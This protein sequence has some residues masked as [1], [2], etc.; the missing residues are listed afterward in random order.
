MMRRTMLYIGLLHDYGDPARGLSYE[1]WNFQRPLERW[2]AE[3]DWDFVAWCP[4][5]AERLAGTVSSGGAG[6][7]V[8]ELFRRMVR[9]TEPD[10]IF[11]VPFE[12]ELAPETLRAVRAEAALVGRDMRVVGWFSDDHW[13]FDG[14]TARY[15]PALLGH[16]GG[17]G[18]VGGGGVD[19][20]GACD[21]YVTTCAG[22]VEKYV[23]AG[24]MRDRVILSQWAVNELVC[25]PSAHA[26]IPMVDV[27]F[28]G[29]A[30]GNRGQLLT[31]MMGEL[32]RIGPEVLG[33]EVTAGIWGTGWRNGRI[34]YPQTVEVWG[35]SRVTL[36]L[37]NAARAVNAIG[38]GIVGGA[39]A[40][41][42]Q[43]KGRHFE[44]AACGGFQLTQPVGGLEECFRVVRSD[45]VGEETDAEIV[46]SAAQNGRDLAY[47][48]AGWLRPEYDELRRRIGQAARARVLA[49]HTWSRR[50]DDI[51]TRVMAEPVLSGAR[52]MTVATEGS[53]SD[54]ELKVEV[55]VGEAAP[56]VIP[57]MDD[58]QARLRGART[59]E[60][61]I[62][63]AARQEFGAA[64]FPATCIVL[65]NRNGAEV[66]PQCLDAVERNTDVP[67]RIVIGDNASDD[68]SFDIASQWAAQKHRRE[69]VK[70]VR[71]DQNL[72]CPEGRHRLLGLM[73]R[74]EKEE[75]LQRAEYVCFLDNDT[76]VPQGWLRLLIEAVEDSGGVWGAVGPRSNMI[77]GPQYISGIC[78]NEGGGVLAVG[79]DGRF[80]G[81]RLPG[82]KGAGAADD[83]ADVPVLDDWA[84]GWAWEHRGRV[85]EIGRLVGFCLLVRRDALDKVGSVDPR[86]GLY[87]F[88]DD[89]LVWR[90]RLAGWRVAIVAG[91]FVH[92]R[93]QLGGSGGGA[94]FDRMLAAAWTRFRE[95]WNLHP[96]MPY[97]AYASLILQYRLGRPW[98]DRRDR[99]VPYE[100]PSS[101]V[102][103]V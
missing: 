62:Q 13:R 99:V 34:P 73:R 8:Q 52:I 61:L 43:L 11:H 26:D 89:D 46:V 36:N 93:S 92:H 24:V 74:W 101:H 51:M 96:S 49:D 79:A 10:V 15:C 20:G 75:D 65:L 3:H 80:S 1:Y 5:R 81:Y 71:F 4:K 19:G 40:P 44:I 57:W 55:E 84:L 90:I 37:T 42:Q 38:V 30:H 69:R 66:L 17:P 47:D 94:E 60:L 32:Q 56:A 6:A 78:W 82:V 29:M 87:G 7:R 33:R 22:A 88:E 9:V 68:G 12:G 77:S 59:I 70:L 63:D 18:K 85:E 97:E 72:G 27:S 35:R 14:F 31:E 41:P 21:W 67:W 100:W 103:R 23:A 28:V 86:F 54:A 48:V 102:F 45:D 2:C 50:L 58:P 16:S 76:V 95:K 83:P 39:V 25:T 98:D 64:G 91:G 53:D